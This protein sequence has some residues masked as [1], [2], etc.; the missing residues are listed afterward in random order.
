MNSS[1]YKQLVALALFATLVAIPTPMSAQAQQRSVKQELIR[2][3]VIDIGTFGGPNSGNNG[4]SVIMNNAGTLVGFA[5]TLA[6][7]PFAPNCFGDCFVQH[8]FEWR[9][10]ALTDLGPLPGG[11]SSSTNAI[12][13][14]GQIVGFSQ[15]G[16]IDPVLGIPEFVAAVWQ[17]G[18]GIDLGTF[19]G[20]F[21]IA[22]AN[23]DL[24]Q[25]VGC[26]L[27][28][29]PDPFAPS[30]MDAFY[31]LGFE[32]LQLRAFRWQGKRLQDL[33][34]L[35]GPD[36]CAVW[37]ND[38][39]Q[40]T[41]TSFTNSIVNPATGLPTLDP[42][43][44]ENGRML[45]LGT[46]GGTVGRA[47]MLN[48]RGQV[49]GQS[50]LAEIPGACLTGD[51]GTSGCHGFIWESGIV[52][53]LGTFG[54]D[55]AIPNWINDAGEIAGVASTQNEQ[56]V[57]GFVW[58]NGILTNLG[59]LAG[60]CFSQAFAINSGGQVVGQSISCDGSVVR[61]VLWQ[62]G[63]II[64]LN[65]FVPPG[66]DLQ[67]TDPKIINDGGKIVLSGLLSNGDA[68]SVVLIPCEAGEEGCLENARA[69]NTAAQNS[70]SHIAP[71]RTAA[72]QTGL[73]PGEIR[74]RV[75]SL[76]AKRNRR[77]G[78]LPQK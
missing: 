62:G 24:Q 19:G 33:G 43:L 68:H 7:D 12:N 57:F 26:A 50:S 32:P 46:L 27:N 22:D 52:T 4:S 29:V 47:L 71:P 13:S 53:D 74:D 78:V 61:P 16:L 72:T 49:I 75:R 25:V 2:Y 54:G 14:A 66:S 42:F 17:G 10:G 18:R 15:N 60:D 63:Q 3:K 65:V 77:F 69:T 64:D 5:D 34:T 51:S 11:S 31:G 59:T 44:W 48:N 35:G 28:D 20:G 58:K 37:I 56:A 21:S 70:A 1:H 67:L 55:F 41:G 40:I 73:T 6:P 9:N 76:L 39:G 30:T 38:L 45:D 8:A 36:A 23:N